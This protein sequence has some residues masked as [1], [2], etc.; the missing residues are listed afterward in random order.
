MKKYI[1]LFIATA[2][3]ISGGILLDQ[4]IEKKAV[5]APL[6][7]VRTGTA[8]Q[9]LNCK[10]KIE[11]SGKR[12]IT[13]QYPLYVE[14]VLVSEGERV[15]EGQALVRV[16]PELT[17]QT[18][19]MAGEIPEAYKDF[20]QADAIPE[21]IYAPA[22]GVVSNIEAEAGKLSLQSSTLM[23][24]TSGSGRQVT[25]TANETQL[26][27]LAVG[28][29]AVIR[30]ASF[31]PQEYHGTVTKIG[32]TARQQLSGTG[33]E[34]VIDVYV[35]VADADENL[36]AGFS[37]KVTVAS[38]QKTDILIVPFSAV[39]QDEEGREFVY[40]YANGWAYKRIVQTGEEFDEGYEILSGLKPGDIIIA[41]ASKYTEKSLKV[42]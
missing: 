13:G 39:N 11:E 41:D 29:K 6:H 42:E 12:S 24:L 9:S 37:A 14:E 2:I 27:G 30:G 23:T 16:D 15:K 26:A 10:G 19:S 1:V 36:R 17:V 32:E 38:G 28:Q 7:T 4:T 22:E 40:V 31:A 21:Y 25:L 8:V 33:Q 34:T 5:Q 18:L 3:L 35:S 20:V